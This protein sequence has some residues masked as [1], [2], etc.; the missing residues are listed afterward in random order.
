[1]SATLQ[2]QPAA[3]A[4]CGSPFV[5]PFCDHVRVALAALAADP[6]ELRTVDEHFADIEPLFA[7]RLLAEVD[8]IVADDPP[9]R[10]Y[11]GADL[12]RGYCPTAAYYAVRR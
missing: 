4:A 2:P 9:R 11:S 10:R 12:R 6:R 8:A 5:E 3:C 7:D 1:M